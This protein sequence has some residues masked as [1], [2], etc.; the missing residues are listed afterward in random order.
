M[1]CRMKNASLV[2]CCLTAGL[3]AVVVG[4]GVFS[5][6][7]TWAQSSKGSTKAV[8]SKGSGAIDLRA[9]RLK[10]SFIREAAE[11]ARSYEEA[12]ELEKSRAML[13]Q[14]LKLDSSLTKVKEKI[15]ELEEN[16]ISANESDFEI[17]VSDSW[18]KPLGQVLKDKPVRFQAAGNYR[19]LAD[20]SLGP[21]G[22][23]AEDLTKDMVGN[24]SC[25]K[26][27]GLIVTDGKPGDPFPIGAG[28]EY[29]PKKD[30]VLFIK[31]NVPPGSRCTGKL[32]IRISGN[33][34]K[35]T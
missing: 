24:V 7:T 15:K 16:L 6:R 17:T 29:T 21:D 32:R 34:Q 35:G 31:A 9:E 22:F 10:D 5:P 30:G 33:F 1:Q 27:M 28:R 20:A 25:G 8:K 2:A 23:P 11:V 3:L 14:I 13:R 26:L 4:M 19:L 18:G 12:N